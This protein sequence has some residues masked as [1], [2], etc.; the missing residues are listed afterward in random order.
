MTLLIFI[1]K[2]ILLFLRVVRSVNKFFCTVH[3]SG[4]LI[5]TLEFAYLVSFIYM[6][7]NDLCKLDSRANSILCIFQSIWKV[8]TCK[9]QQTRSKIVH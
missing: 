3:V 2:A 1:F 4:P 8:G 9:L 7:E 6:V 5:N